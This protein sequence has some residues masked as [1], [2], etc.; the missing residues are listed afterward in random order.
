MSVEMRDA[1]TDLTGSKQGLVDYLTK[2]ERQRRTARELNL[3]GKR[4]GVKCSWQVC[5]YPY[6]ISSVEEQAHQQVGRRVQD[7]R[8]KD[9]RQWRGV[10]KRRIKVLWGK[11]LDRVETGYRFDHL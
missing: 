3:M 10:I 2:R 1:L 7:T 5:V 8:A 11:S 9:V 6:T 4:V